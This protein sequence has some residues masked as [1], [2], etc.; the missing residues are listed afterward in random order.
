MPAELL[1]A[2]ALLVALALYCLGAGADFGGGVWDLL[3]RGP[4]AA[5]QRELVAHAIGPIWEANH[6]WLILVVVLLFVCFPAG[7]APLMTGLFVPLT[8]LLFGIVL[9]GSAFAFRSYG[10]VSDRSQARWGRVFAVSS[11][12]SPLMLGACVGAIA[13]GAV[14]VPVALPPRLL[15]PWLAPFP[16]AIGLLTLALFAFLA[17][18]YLTLE[19]EEAGLREDFRRRALA[20][21]VLVGALALGSLGLARG[22]APLVYAALT[23]S[24]WALPFHLVTA[25]CALAALGALYR[26]RFARARALAALQATLL[27]AGWALAQ[28][29]WLL[30]PGLSFAEAAAPRQVL[31]PVLLALAGGA[32][33]LV[34]SL[35]YLFRV[36]KTARPPRG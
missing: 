11:L 14:P 6:V 28:Y 7:F 10:D 12:V 31:E 27:L 8:L 26:R 15:E 36:F 3:A 34:P 5:A 16:L 35:V 20:S 22:G 13:A 23:T 4:R 24:S 30:P 21:G 32:L 17:A 1:V 18:V 25:G 33:L 9:R 19:A 2:G 29:P